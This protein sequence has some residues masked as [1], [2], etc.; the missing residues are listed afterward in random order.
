MLGK[1]P[2]EKTKSCTRPCRKQAASFILGKAFQTSDQESILQLTHHRPESLPPVEQASACGLPRSLIHASLT[3]NEVLFSAEGLTILALDRLYSLKSAL[4]AYHKT[5]SPM[6]LEDAVDELRRLVLASGGRKV[7]KSDLL[8]SYDWL[9]ISHSAISDL[10]RMYRRAYGGPEQIGGIAGMT[11]S[12]ARQVHTYRPGTHKDTDDDAD[13]LIGK[14]SESSINA[15]S[16]PP[17]EWDKPPSPKLS[18]LPKIQTT[19]APLPVAAVGSSFSC[20]TVSM[21]T[22]TATRPNDGRVTMMQQW[23]PDS[24][25]DNIMTAGALSP[26]RASARLGPITPNKYDDISPI[27]RGEWGFLMVDDAFRGVRTAAVETC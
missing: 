16:I 6:R 27:T 25:I 19:F 10:D 14:A 23:G 24:S 5:K 18:Q 2:L 7:T 13:T 26:E 17:A 3:Q 11:A 4:S 15:A 22:T 12:R 21:V 1:P 8:R 9:G 20:R